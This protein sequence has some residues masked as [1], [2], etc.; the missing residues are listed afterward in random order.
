MNGVK[1]VGIENNSSSASS[2]SRSRARLLQFETDYETSCIEAKNLKQYLTQYNVFHT[3][4]Q[5]GGVLHHRDRDL[6]LDLSHH[7]P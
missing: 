3:L 7:Q 5:I 2:R 6:P 4:S 1:V